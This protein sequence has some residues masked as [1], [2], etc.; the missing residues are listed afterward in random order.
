MVQVF[1]GPPVVPFLTP[2]LV[3]SVPYQNRLQTK[4]GTLIPTSLPEEPVS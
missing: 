4:V 1:P 3:G 2:F